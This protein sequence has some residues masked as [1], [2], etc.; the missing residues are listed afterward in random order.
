[1]DEAAVDLEGEVVS[2]SIPAPPTTTFRRRKATLDTNTNSL[3]GSRGGF[4][5]YGPPDTLIELGTFKHAAE[6]DMVY[7]SSE[8]RVPKFNSSIYLASK[9]E[10]GKCDEIFG[11]VRDPCFTVKPGSGIIATSFKTGDKVFVGSDRILPKNMCVRRNE[12]LYML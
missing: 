1:M 12:L 3:P 5:S 11:T 8:S 10:I 9:S 7:V 6:G 4:Q 2:T